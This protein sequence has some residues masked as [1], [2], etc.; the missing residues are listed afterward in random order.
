MLIYEHK[1]ALALEPPFILPNPPPISDCFTYTVK[2][3]STPGEKGII[4]D[5]LM[6]MSKRV[7]NGVLTRQ[8]YGVDALFKSKFLNLENG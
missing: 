6:T 4:G 2:N 8:T 5:R 1:H 3:E 7:E